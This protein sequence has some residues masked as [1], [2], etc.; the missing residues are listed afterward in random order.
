MFEMR[1]ERQQKY[2]IA[3]VYDA[4]QSSASLF[5]KA[6]AT[7]TGVAMPS[8]VVL[9]GSMKPAFYRGD[10]LFITND[11]KRELQVGDIVVFKL[12]NKN[13]PIVHRIIK[14]FQSGE[15]VKFLTKGDNNRVDDTSLYP[16]GKRWL[17]REDV[18]GVAKGYIPYAGYVTILLHENH[19]LRYI[20][21]GIFAL[22]VLLYRE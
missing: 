3:Y 8:T 6:L 9:S 2:P 19:K 16:E 7:W 12:S 20:V 4:I 22:S 10:V 14:L 5:W 11:P 15:S 13:V 18:I 21:I 1:L 17:T